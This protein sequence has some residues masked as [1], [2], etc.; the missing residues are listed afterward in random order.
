MNKNF[1]KNKETRKAIKRDNL[2]EGNGGKK[3]VPLQRREI[4]KNV[5]KNVIKNETTIFF[6]IDKFYFNRL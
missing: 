3:I 4:W 6:N 1:T 5:I 2:M